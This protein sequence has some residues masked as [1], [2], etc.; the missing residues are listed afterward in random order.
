M[1][2]VDCILPVHK[3]QVRSNFEENSEGKQSYVPGPLPIEGR[4]RASPWGIYLGILASG[5]VKAV[6]EDVLRSPEW[7]G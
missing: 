6:A 3:E 5:S 2:H 7:R 1:Y 4:A